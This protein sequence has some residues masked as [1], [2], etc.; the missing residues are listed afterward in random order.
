MQKPGGKII[1]NILDGGFKGALYAVNPRE[2]EIE[3]VQCYSDVEWLPECDLAILAVPASLCPEIVNILIRDKGT[4]AFIIISA[5]FAEDGLTGKMLE[6]QITNSINSVNGSLIGPNCI[7]ILTPF[8]HS[9]FTSPIPPVDSQGCDLIS[10]SGATAVF[11]MESGITKGLKFSSVF[12]VGNAAQNGIEDVLEFLDNTFDEAVSSKIK[13]LYIENIKD[14]DKLLYHASSL[15]KKGS[16]IAA[17]KAGVSEAGS[18][19]ALSHT[20][21]LAGADSAVEALFRKAGIVRCLGREELTTTA[22]IFMHKEM[23]GKRVVIVTHAGGPAVM[24]TDALS[25]GRLEI[26]VIPEDI[27]LT[28]RQHLFPGASVLNPIDLLATGT[29]QQLDFILTTCDK[30]TFIDAVLVIFGSPGLVEVFDAYEVLHNHMIHALKPIFPVLPSII[31]AQN[32]VKYF[33]SQGHVNF[34]DEVMLGSALVNVLN[35]PKPAGEIIMPGDIDFDSIRKLILSSPDGFLTPKNV[36][37]IFQWAGIPVV[38][39]AV[40]ENPE[41][42]FAEAENMGYPIVAKV[43]GPV[44]KSDVGG[45]ALNIK[46]KD[47]LKAVFDHLIQLPGAVAVMIQPMLSGRELFIGAKYEPRFGH[48]VLC[49]LGGI[50]VE[51]LG[52]ISSG[53]APLTLSEAYSMIHA[54]KVYPIFKGMRGQEGINE[55]IFADIIVR[56]SCVLRLN[57]EIKEVDLNPL[58]GSANQITVVDARILIKK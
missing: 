37:Q 46:T 55:H 22:C 16:R 4:K 43:V 20:G 17:I 23:N 8:H 11:I 54:L 15:I 41:L 18:R 1:R 10:S 9:L 42:L 19:A 30:M 35:T 57:I 12:S 40:S 38:P 27:A 5:G 13:L 24:L 3:G 14:P 31:T 7:G 34:P 21:A 25:K 28:L 50:F 48:V 39:E 58:L 32:E 6:E 51:T 36:Q 29:A 56:L 26:P 44:H 45:V 53:L 52:D 49:G 33:I 2:K 47:Q